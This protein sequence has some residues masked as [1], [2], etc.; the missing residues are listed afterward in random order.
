MS[1]KPG[2]DHGTAAPAGVYF[3][4]LHTDAGVKTQRVTMVH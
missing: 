1:S 4:Q 3:V 2:T